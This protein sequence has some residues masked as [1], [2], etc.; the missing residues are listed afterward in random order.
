MSL[1]VCVLLLARS[2]SSLHLAFQSCKV[3]LSGSSRKLINNWPCWGFVRRHSFARERLHLQQPAI[4]C[5]SRLGRCQQRCYE[6]HALLQRGH[7]S[8]NLFTSM[9]GHR[10][11]PMR[12]CEASRQLDRAAFE[13]T[14]VLKALSLPKQECHR[15][16]KLLKR[17]T[18]YP[19]CHP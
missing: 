14:L 10:P 1:D 17:W 2:Y 16:M 13:K 18:N 9:R 15:Y 7:E 19:P 4:Y 8:T 12:A 5:Q 11:Y 3:M 6:H